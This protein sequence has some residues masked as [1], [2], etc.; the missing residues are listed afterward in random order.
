MKLGFRG[1]CRDREY[2]EY[3]D[4][5]DWAKYVA[6]LAFQAFLLKMPKRG[7][8]YISKPLKSTVAPTMPLGINLGNE[9]VRA[10][11]FT[12]SCNNPSFVTRGRAHGKCLQLNQFN[13]G[14]CS[15]VSTMPSKIKCG[16][17]GDP[18]PLSA[19]SLC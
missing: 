5:K 15:L 7:R 14:S 3:K 6:E 11:I 8:C 13:Q 2:S 16:C 1:S 4:R 18:T 19:C 12:L 17:S 9:H 10:S